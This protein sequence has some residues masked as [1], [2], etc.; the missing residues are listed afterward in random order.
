[1][2]AYEDVSNRVLNNRGD[3]SEYPGHGLDFVRNASVH[4]IKYISF[5]YSSKRRRK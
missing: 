1:M 4:P 3:D 2:T 5:I